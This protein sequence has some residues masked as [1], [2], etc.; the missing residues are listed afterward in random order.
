MDWKAKGKIMSKELSA[1]PLPTRVP[2]V[3]A[4]TVNVPALL[5]PDR[6]VGTRVGRRWVKRVVEGQLTV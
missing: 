5:L 1:L 2:P 3:V 6:D 4:E